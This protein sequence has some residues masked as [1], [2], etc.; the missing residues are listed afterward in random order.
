MT[1]EIPCDYFKYQVMLFELINALT[2]FQ[3]YMNK[4][5]AEKLDILLLFN[6]ITFLSILKVR[7]KNI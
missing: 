7:K 4:I 3:S 1:F 5:L 6:L 2:T